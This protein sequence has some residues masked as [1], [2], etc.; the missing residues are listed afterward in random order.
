M[1]PPVLAST[2]SYPATTDARARPDQSAAPRATATA[3]PQAPVLAQEAAVAS[4]LNIMLLSGPERMSQNLATLAEVLG[5][6]LKIERRTNE[7]LSDYMGRLIEGIAAL[8]AA[9]RLKLQRLLAQSFAGLQLRTLLE[10]MAS[11]SGP[12]RATL[13]L[14]LELYRQTDRDGAMRSVISSYRELA[15]ESRATDPAVARRIA[16]NDGG[17]PTLPG[18]PASDQKLAQVSQAA[19]LTEARTLGGGNADADSPDAPLERALPPDAARPRTAAMYP[20]QSPAGQEQPGRNSRTAA[21]PASAAARESARMSGDGVSRQALSDAPARPEAPAANAKLDTAP[22]APRSAVADVPLETDADGSLVPERRT[23]TVPVPVTIPAPG[24][25]SQT[26][27]A[28]WLAELLDTDFVRALLQLKTLPADTRQGT[29]AGSLPGSPEQAMAAPGTETEAAAVRAVTADDGSQ[30][31]DPASREA[32]E[33]RSTPLPV[34]LPEQAAIRPTLSREGLP[35]PFISYLIDDDFEIGE[36]EEEEE[37][38]GQDQ[39]SDEDNEAQDL[40]PFEEPA[41]EEGEGSDEVEAAL[42]V[43]TD[44]LIAT[45]ERAEGATAQAALP[46]PTDRPFG[47]Q[48]EPAHQLYLRMAGLT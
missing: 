38:P 26:L 27:P 45:E 36:V 12:E 20:S 37:R 23:V 14:Y 28:S 16:A 1:L 5:S 33:E 13:T 35:L 18:S 30:P 40:A 31:F 41:D 46:S 43:A 10:A 48:T 42:A 47:L 34:A 7:T 19:P 6:A 32:V 4:Q 44:P 8:P 9:D 11:P 2:N 3:T 22:A 25:A 15:G 17:R 29:P 21:D 39:D 24:Q